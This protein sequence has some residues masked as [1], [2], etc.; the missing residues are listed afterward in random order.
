[1]LGRVYGQTR[2]SPAEKDSLLSVVI[3]IAESQEGIRERTGNNDGEVEKYLKLVGLRRGN[4]YCTSGLFWVYNEA[5]VRLLV[6]N[7]AYSPNWALKPMKVVYRKVKPPDD[8]VMEK[9]DIM[10]FYIPTKK[11]IGHGELIKSEFGEYYKTTGFN[12]S[13]TDTDNGDGV[14][15]MLRK[16]SL[17]YIIVRP[18]ES[19]FFYKSKLFNH[20]KN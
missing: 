4:P 20:L 2:L 7:P 12:T 3:K 11:R 15:P 9:G 18:S 5:G 19:E 10:L 13:G 8:Y 14:R 16:K 17:A 1:M 6:E